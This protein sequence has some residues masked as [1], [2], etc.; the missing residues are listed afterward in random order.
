[1]RL[2]LNAQTK[3]RDARGASLVEMLIVVTLIGIVAAWAVLRIVEARQSVY[4][5]GATQELIAYLDKARLDSIRRRAT[6]LNQMAQVSITSPTSYSVSLDTNGDGQLDP[7]RVFNFPAGSITF[8]VADFPTI[9]RFNWRGRVV[10]GSGEQ[11]S[12]P[13]EISLQDVNGPGPAI[14]LSAAGDTTP[15]GNVNISNVNVSSVSGITNIRRRT[16]VPQ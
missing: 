4:L 10:D 16:Q 11:M 8:N 7:P 3:W 13:A 5:S 15:H 9:V 1:M 12:T 2:P 14:N 6:A